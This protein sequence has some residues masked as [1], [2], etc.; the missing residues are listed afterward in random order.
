MIVSH[1]YLT[2][3]ATCVKNQESSIGF[4]NLAHLQSIENKCK[5][6]NES[7]SRFV[8]KFLFDLIVLTDE[9]KKLLYPL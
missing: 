3:Y 6:L 9:T 2:F 5:L 8:L 7:L 1:C 4:Q